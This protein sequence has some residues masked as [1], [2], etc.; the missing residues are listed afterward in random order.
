MYALALDGD[1]RPCSV[2]TSNAGQCLFS[3]IPSANHA[4]RVAEALLRPELFSGWGIRTL[5]MGESRYNPMGYHTGAVWPH[6]NAL[7]AFGMMRYGMSRHAARIF[8]A[9]FDAALYCDLHRLPELF[10][11]FAREPGE[12]PVLYPVACAP[13]AWSAG[14][15]FLLL[16]GCLGLTINALERKVVFARPWLPAFLTH[17]RMSNLTVCDG[18]VDILVV[19]HAHDLSVNVLG[20]KGHVDVVVLP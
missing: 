19:R 11:G 12:G 15:V 7:I 8:T 13:Q 16:Q 4:T 3:G 18:A 9:L 20:Q 5:A 14:A 1:N 2:R 6:D 17:I 10:C